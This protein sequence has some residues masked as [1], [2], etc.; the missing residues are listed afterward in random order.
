VRD[1]VSV[2]HPYE[3]QNV[4]GTLGPLDSSC[5]MRGREKSM[6]RRHWGWCYGR[7]QHGPICYGWERG[8]QFH[9]CVT[10]T[11]WHDPREWKL[12]H[13][14]T[15]AWHHQPTINQDGQE[16]LL[17]NKQRQD[18]PPSPVPNAEASG[19]AGSRDSVH[20][21]YLRWASPMYSN[22]GRMGCKCTCITG[23]V[24]LYFVTSRT[25]NCTKGPGPFGV[26]VR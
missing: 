16:L 2:V 11:K 12:W 17:E 18:A 24:G 26:T 23:W 25:H 20:V 1:G 10:D 22:L 14:L 4:T 21:L 6:A 19:D 8:C 15:H 3:S 13:P 7:C 5:V 9:G